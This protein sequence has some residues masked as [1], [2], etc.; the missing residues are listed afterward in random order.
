MR[1]KIIKILLLGD[2]AGILEAEQATKDESKRMLITAGKYALVA[3]VA[4]M[5][6][7]L[8]LQLLTFPYQMKA[9]KA[10]TKVT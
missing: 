8:G 7:W 1:D 4:L 10:L 9:A 5:L 2:P 3:I 6:V